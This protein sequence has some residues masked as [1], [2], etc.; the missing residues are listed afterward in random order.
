MKVA[1]NFLMEDAEENNNSS[2]Y[3]IFSREL[4]GSSANDKRKFVLF[5]TVRCY[6]DEMKRTWAGSGRNYNNLNDHE[7]LHHHEGSNVITG[8]FFDVDGKF[9]NAKNEDLDE[10]WD[11][12]VPMDETHDSNIA[13]PG[14]ALF[15]AVRGELA[16]KT[17][18]LVTAILSLV[19]PKQEIGERAAVDIKS[20]ACQRII[21]QE[22]S[23][24][25]NME[26]ISFHGL[27]K[28]KYGMFAS[29]G[30]VEM[31]VL[32]ATCLCVAKYGMDFLKIVALGK[33]L[34]KSWLDLGI[35]RDNRSFRCL[36][37]TKRKC[38][39]RPFLPSVTSTK[40]FNQNISLSL[41]RKWSN[42]G[43]NLDVFKDSLI[44]LP[45]RWLKTPISKSSHLY[46]Y[47]ATASDNPEVEASA[48]SRN[49]FIGLITAS[50]R[51]EMVDSIESD[52]VECRLLSDLHAH[53][54][55]L[56]IE[57][58]SFKRE[59]VCEVEE[60]V[61]SSSNG[62]RLK[63]MLATLIEKHVYS[64]LDAKKG[65][66]S[67]VLVKMHD[68]K[69]NS[70][71][72]KELIS[73]NA[74]LFVKGEKEEARLDSS[75]SL[76]IFC[77]DH[78]KVDVDVETLL[79][80]ERFRGKE[81]GA[82]VCFK[83]AIWVFSSENHYCTIKGFY[84]THN[85][86]FYVVDLLKK[87]WSQRC[88]SEECVA[89]TAAEVAK[90]FRNDGKYY[91]FKKKNDDNTLQFGNESKLSPSGKG[92][93]ISIPPDHRVHSDIEIYLKNILEAREERKKKY[94]EEARAFSSSAS[95]SSE[96]S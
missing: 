15:Q 63:Y 72:D 53:F 21:I 27:V 24:F 66:L 73:N 85:R 61:S 36:F 13:E 7:L 93:K 8:V 76:P 33:R 12:G 22:S 79:R 55:S 57:Y 70:Q 86:V 10:V 18:I 52:D 35:Y 83:S 46:L 65:I 96:H 71:K 81:M 45:I 94:E 2:R 62:E 50:W 95:S 60:L 38:K 47:R 39:G 78:I 23:D 16:D 58:C 34:K 6:Y 80:D 87:E 40:E 51:S 43:P 4:K 1:L 49:R 14:K 44:V 25:E 19:D 29:L 89:K 74:I 37:N 90:A 88:F 67:D 5:P 68:G 42:C 69:N 91:K 77:K 75:I 84:H 82:A 64:E 28:L 59:N 9:S 92:P 54:R 17:R 48:T 11:I 56:M 3:K 20:G 41:D 26:C 32:D 31:M 30:E